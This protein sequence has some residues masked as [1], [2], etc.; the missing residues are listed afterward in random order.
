MALAALALLA[1]F[2]ALA[3]EAGSPEETVRRYLTAIKDGHFED[4]YD[5]I[6]RAMK[7]GKERE[8][9]AK[10][11]KAEMAFADV[12]IFEFEVY[13]AK[14]EGD[15]AR[16]PNVLSSQDRFINQLG[17]TE[18]ELYTLVRED[19]SWKVDQQVIVEPPD[20]PKWFPTAPKGAA[21]SG[22]VSSH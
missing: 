14:V 22:G 4:A 20:I 3:F 8:V 17:L 5:L 13:P 10:E 2:V 7:G 11:Q 9:W 12:K 21:A 16:V 18:H 19:G 15:R 1:P 6:S